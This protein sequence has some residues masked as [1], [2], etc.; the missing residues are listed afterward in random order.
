LSGYEH[1]E[2]AIR[3]LQQ[4]H[5]MHDV[6]VGME[7]TGHYW[8]NV[9]NWLMDR[10][11]EVMLVNPA[12][13]KRNKEN[14]DNSPSK[15]DPKD[16]LVI[17]DV[18]SRGYYTPYKPSDELFQRL[19][20]L[21]KNREHWV[22]E[23]GRLQNQITRWLDIR[24]PEYTSV[25]KEIFTPRSL[26]TLRSFPYANRLTWTNSTRNRRGVEKPYVSGWRS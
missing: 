11:I 8:F 10:G 6:V 9:A 21:V 18:V 13:T 1:L 4:N 5:G 16:A 12:T 3:K 24:F 15:S 26:A 22:V 17:A 2:R 25:F 14:R 19:R 20:I 7:S 23:S